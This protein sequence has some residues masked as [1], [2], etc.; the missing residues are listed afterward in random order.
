MMVFIGSDSR[1]TKGKIYKVQKIGKLINL[2][3][4]VDGNGNRFIGD[5]KDF[6][7]LKQHRNNILKEI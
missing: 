1:F 6:I 4:I 3:S 2:C 7:T 5:R